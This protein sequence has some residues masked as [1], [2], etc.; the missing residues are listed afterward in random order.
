MLEKL[1]FIFDRHEHRLVL[2]R[3]NN[4][5]IVIFF[6][7]KNFSI[8][9]EILFENNWKE[10]VNYYPSNANNKRK[11]ISSNNIYIKTESTNREIKIHKISSI[12]FYISLYLFENVENK[13]EIN[14]YKIICKILL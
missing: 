11:F 4:V 7:L 8:I 10:I 2:C 1:F 12:S 14:A 5:I 9:L 6:S 13:K 3:I